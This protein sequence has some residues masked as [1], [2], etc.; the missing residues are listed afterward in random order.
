[1]LGNVCDKCKKVIQERQNKSK[2]P[3]NIEKQPHFVES[4]DKLCEKLTH[5]ESYHMSSQGSISSVNSNTTSSSQEVVK[6]SKTMSNES[7][8]PSNVHAICSEELHEQKEK[9]IQIAELVGYDFAHKYD[10]VLN[11]DVNDAEKQGRLKPIIDDL[12]KLF[13]KVK[14]TCFRAVAPGQEKELQEIYEH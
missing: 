13:D 9:L 5:N 3:L 11:V 6:I 12:S 2:T 8:K 10:R 4:T 1:M 7:Y 14:E